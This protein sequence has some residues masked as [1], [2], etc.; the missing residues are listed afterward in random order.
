VSAGGKQRPDVKE[1]R[2]KRSRSR[3]T[4]QDPSKPGAEMDGAQ[5]IVRPLRSLHATMPLD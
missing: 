3:D 4:R 5:E 2:T 1:A